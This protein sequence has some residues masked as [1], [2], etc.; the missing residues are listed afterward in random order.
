MNDADAFYKQLEKRQLSSRPTDADAVDR[1][2]AAIGEPL[3][4]PSVEHV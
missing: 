1:A 4:P 3:S 2:I